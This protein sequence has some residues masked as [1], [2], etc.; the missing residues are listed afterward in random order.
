MFIP[1]TVDNPHDK[2]HEAVDRLKVVKECVDYL[3]KNNI[4]DPKRIGITGHSQ[5]GYLTLAAVT[6][7]P[8]MFAACVERA[9]WVDFSTATKNVS[10]DWANFMRSEYGDPSQNP[11][12]LDVLSPIRRLDKVTAAIMVQHGAQDIVVPPDEAQQVVDYFKK[13]NVEVE[14]LIVPDEGHNFMKRSNQ[15]K[16]SVA[17]I[18]FFVRHLKPQVH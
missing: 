10:V 4:V 8:N 17:L 15:V 3:V 14:A 11:E 5:F 1:P 2:G 12:L 9:G 18:D 13:K 16:S 6:E 7:F